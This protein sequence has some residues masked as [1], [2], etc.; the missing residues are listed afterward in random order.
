M[1]KTYLVVLFF[2]LITLLISCGDDSSSAAF[3]LERKYWTTEDYR[4]VNSELSSLKFNEKELPNLDNP[5]TAPIFKKIV[6]TT[7]FSI[8]ASDDQLGIKHRSKF[9]S[10]MFDQYKELV[11][12]YS[13]IDRKD[14]YQ[15][16]VEFVEILKFGLALQVYYIKTTNENNIKTA[17]DPQSEE[18]VNLVRRNEDVLIGNYNLYLDY[19]NYE[20]RFND[21]A[22][23]SYSEGLKVF[24]PKLINNVVPGGDYTVMLNKVGNMLK[25]SKN[26]LIIVQ[27]QNI[28]N[29][30]KNKTQNTID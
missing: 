7:N 9:T 24:F 20:D 10:D 26:Q 11:S 23:S 28:Q 15:Y 19:I 14:K 17:D 21:D 25:K 12:T 6:D 16:P 2:A 5:K 18:V 1:K 13:G 3:P 22:L 8:V 29:L 30:L 4:D 27:L